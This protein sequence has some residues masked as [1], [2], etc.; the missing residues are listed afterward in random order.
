[1]AAVVVSE[2]YTTNIEFRLRPTCKNP[3]PFA[4]YRDNVICNGL[5]SLDPLY[6][7]VHGVISGDNAHDEILPIANI[8]LK[9]GNDYEN[10]MM[11]NSF[12]HT[13]NKSVSEI[14]NTFGTIQEM[15]DAATFAKAIEL[16]KDKC[17]IVDIFTGSYFCPGYNNYIDCADKSYKN[18]IK[19]VGLNNPLKPNGGLLL[20]LFQQYD[21][22]KFSALLNY[23][24]LLYVALVQGDRA[25]DQPSIEVLDTPLK[26][27]K[28]MNINVMKFFW[29]C[30]LDETQKAI[31]GDFILYNLGWQQHYLQALAAIR[32]INFNGIDISKDG[33]IDNLTWQI[34][35]VFDN[36]TY[37]W[38]ITQGTS[39]SSILSLFKQLIC[40]IPRG[41]GAS[42]KKDKMGCSIGLNNL[43]ASR[44]NLTIHAA[45]ALHAVCKFMGDTSHITFGN[46]IQLAKDEMKKVGFLDK[47]NDLRITLSNPLVPVPITQNDIESIKIH[48]WV[49]ERPMATRLCVDKQHVKE[50]SVGI[51]PTQI[52]KKLYT[53]N[54]FDEKKDQY[55]LVNFDELQASKA[56]INDLKNIFDYL[57]RLIPPPSQRF[58]DDLDHL[59]TFPYV[60]P[61]N[62][63]TAVKEFN[64]IHK[65][66]LLRLKKQ[67]KNI[68]L[69]ADIIS[70]LVPGQSI[71]AV[72]T[73]LEMKSKTGSLAVNPTIDSRK[74]P[75]QIN[76]DGWG[77]LNKGVKRKAVN[78]YEQY[79][80]ITRS[81]SLL[82]E[83]ISLDDVE[84]NDKKKR[85]VDHLI[86]NNKALYWL[87]RNL[88]N[89]YVKHS[90]NM[91]SIISTAL[92]TTSNQESDD[93]CLYASNF[94]ENVVKLNKKIEEVEHIG[95]PVSFV[96]GG[97]DVYEMMQRGL[98]CS[99]DEITHGKV[100]T[101]DEN[102]KTYVL[103]LLDRDIP[104][105]LPY[106]ELEIPVNK[107]SV[108]EQYND[109]KKYL[110]S[111]ANKML[112]QEI[113]YK[114]VGPFI[115]YF[116]GE[117]VT[118]YD[119]DVIVNVND[120]IEIFIKKFIEPIIET[121][122]EYD[123]ATIN[124][125]PPPHYTDTD[126][127][128]KEYYDSLY[129]KIF[130][131]LDN[132]HEYY[133]NSIIVKHKSHIYTKNYMYH[134]LMNE[135]NVHEG[136]VKLYNL[137]LEENLP[138]LPSF[139]DGDI[140]FIKN[141]ANLSYDT[142]EIDEIRIIN[143]YNIL[144]KAV[145]TTVCEILKE[146]LILEMKKKTE[147]ST[148][149][150]SFHPGQKKNP[151]NS[152]HHR[153]PN[154]RNAV[155]KTLFKEIHP[156]DSIISTNSR[157]TKRNT[158]FEPKN[159]LPGSR[160][161]S[162]SSS[163]SF[164]RNRISHA[165]GKHIRTR[166]YVKSKK[167]KKTRRLNKRLKKRATN[168][169]NHKIKKYT[170]RYR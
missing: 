158:L 43:I 119:D 41:E 132:I 25:Y 94:I 71:A 22:F 3:S 55:L 5:D 76:P 120:G 13:D 98:G 78:I 146:M 130:G 44:P 79:I 81:V 40:C 66:E 18:F 165:G 147:S 52:I 115:V 53:N 122:I 14:F 99:N 24:L 9:G 118:F 97:L 102:L 141:Y 49:S 113:N 100:V 154:A 82:L 162:L 50:F 138:E 28:H 54:T 128:Y 67:Y 108:W 163:N 10:N 136:A 57:N 160:Y 21:A 167:L 30:L 166:K 48:F 169:K 46:I 83:Y 116:N 125:F 117:T 131:K 74:I 65:D 135:H 114:M 69:E 16:N 36:N 60:P 156:G 61:Q 127:D 33:N 148:G 64:D 106:D 32:K 112:S 134:Y 121:V 7:Y 19:T 17:H 88:G 89:L 47:L 93:F 1:M 104:I 70:Y 42:K 145:Y 4:A 75:K 91:Y 103:S 73:I 111:V 152:R 151:K 161:Y 38:G 149:L 51:Q 20:F 80:F 27:V 133:Y 15:P 157:G 39:A 139:T 72:V 29:K 12:H 126:T 142:K 92:A 95:I 90:G 109:D 101:H 164:K 87:I 45:A 144:Y 31:E 153:R 86:A 110:I 11:E 23:D 35:D 143:E 168:H 62:L 129:E 34:D 137:V 77:T 56:F 150:V 155:N 140:Q 26:F 105:Y 170:R 2:P 63:N 37:P 68:K 123:T 59:K 84:L 6:P 159:P 107:K 124:S 58:N 8:K 96:G 85:M